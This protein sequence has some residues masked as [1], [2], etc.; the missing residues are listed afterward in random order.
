MKVFLKDTIQD[1]NITDAQQL[2]NTFYHLNP[3]G[4]WFDKDTMRFFNTRVQHSLIK[5]VNKV[6]YF[7]TSEKY[8]D[9]PRRYSLR[10]MSLVT[11]NMDTIGE[12]NEMTRSQAVKAFNSVTA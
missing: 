9:D 11:G 7:V 10:S 2:S 1:L 8:L 6:V 3:R 4:H 12:F 5:T